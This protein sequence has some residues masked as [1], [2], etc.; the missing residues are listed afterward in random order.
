MSSAPSTKR[1]KLDV[2]ETQTPRK[3]RHG[4]VGNAPAVRPDSP[5][6]SEHSPRASSEP[7]S[8][9]PPRTAETRKKKRFQPQKQQQ[10]Q[11]QPPQQP[12]KSALSSPLRARQGE[13]G[14][15]PALRK[16]VSF[17]SQPT[18]FIFDNSSYT[19]GPARERRR[20]QREQQQ[21]ET[22]ASS[23][24]S[25]PS[26]RWLHTSPAATALRKALSPLVP[27]PL[28]PKKPK[29]V[30]LSP[31][32]P[33]QPKRS[34]SIPSSP[35]VSRVLQLKSTNTLPSPS[36]PV[37]PRVLLPKCSNAAPSPSSPLVPRTP[38]PKSTN[39]LP[40]PSS[41]LA[42]RVLPP[43]RSNT[44]PSPS[45]NP[46]PAS[47]YPIPLRNYTLLPDDADDDFLDEAARA[48]VE[49]APVPTKP[50]ERPVPRASFVLAA[51]QLRVRARRQIER[52]KEK[53]RKERL[54]GGCSAEQNVSREMALLM[55]FIEEN[56]REHERDIRNGVYRL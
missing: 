55:N 50:G 25:R 33:Q 14:G 27:Q 35:L 20:R 24:S 45:S 17:D 6:P 4:A 29:T 26:P 11:K 16:K 47:P 10:K 15:T 41:P 37:V 36:S 31:L 22:D 7:R 9:Y 1:P 19:T 38:Q 32:I 23:S 30:P 44:L 46:S 34:T 56:K 52:E 2:V 18:Y 51:E 28:Q 3:V 48:V 39:T 53:E 8:R 49:R 42:P 21:K 13:E 54:R 43:K 5:R 40:S 12:K